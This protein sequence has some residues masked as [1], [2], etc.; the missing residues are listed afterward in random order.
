[1]NAPAEASRSVAAAR[2]AD[3]RCSCGSLLARKIGDRLELKCRR[4]KR[5][6]G[7]AVMVEKRTSCECGEE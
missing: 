6:V 4:C 2:S 5:V 3:V 7:I 1:M